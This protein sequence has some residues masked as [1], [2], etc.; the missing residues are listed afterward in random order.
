MLTHECSISLPLYNAH[1]L[2]RVAMPTRQCFNLHEIGTDRRKHHSC[3]DLKFLPNPHP[4]YNIPSRS[5]IPTWYVI[6]FIS[7]LF[8]LPV[9]RI[10]D[11][12]APKGQS[13]RQPKQKSGSRDLT[14]T[15]LVCWLRRER[16]VYN[17]TA[18]LR[19]TIALLE[20]S[21]RHASFSLHTFRS[22]YSYFLHRRAL[23]GRKG[24]LAKWH[25][26]MH[27]TTR[28]HLPT[29][30]KHSHS[31][32][33]VV[34]SACSWGVWV[35]CSER[36]DRIRRWVRSGIWR[37]MLVLIVRLPPSSHPFNRSGEYIKREHAD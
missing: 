34:I 24:N 26:L 11:G 8:I 21:H 6:S 27:C 31:S 19:I 2:N 32:T 5:R 10:G 17:N 16:V 15:M 7:V 23:R 35:T 3:N 25:L 29:T 33:S 36:V 9:R 12:A 28:R 13:R 20:H 1:R 4:L 37:R 30:R 18:I 22:T 14:T